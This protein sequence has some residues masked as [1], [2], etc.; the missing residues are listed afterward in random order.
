MELAFGDGGGR[1][2]NQ[3]EPLEKRGST[4]RTF[5]QAGPDCDGHKHRCPASPRAVAP[6]FVTCGL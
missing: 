2:T 4:C 3:E 5:L 1:G 6:L